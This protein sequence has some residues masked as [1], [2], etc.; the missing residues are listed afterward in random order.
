MYENLLHQPVV[1]QLKR[2]I[3]NDSFPGAVLFSGPQ[4][5]GKLTCALETSRVLSCLHN[6]KASWNC[7]CPSCLRAKAMT[8]GNLILTGPRDC[9]PEIK[10][11]AQTFL[12]ALK[13]NASYLN[14]TRYL[15]IRS[16]RKLTL[17]FNQ[18]LWEND[19]KLSKIAS[20]TSDID[21]ELEILDYPHELPESALVEK[22]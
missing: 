2:D 10:A 21:E 5:S 8:T 19:D 14:A 3:K 1:S 22:A 6:P 17:R 18:V 20:I 7:N 15:F 11:S 12:K 9:S 13:E 4:S 16:I